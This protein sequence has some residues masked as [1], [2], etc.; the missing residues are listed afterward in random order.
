MTQDKNQLFTFLNHR[1]TFVLMDSDVPFAN[2]KF[3]LSTNVCV[4]VCVC[5]CMCVCVRVG[6][7][8]LLLSCLNASMLV[9]LFLALLL[10]TFKCRFMSGS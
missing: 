3:V 10:V 5:V 6:A 1:A 8:A 2:G 7:I 4:C 9:N